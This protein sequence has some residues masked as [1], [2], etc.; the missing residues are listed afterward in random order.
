MSVV[1]ETC[2]LEAEVPWLPPVPVLPFPPPVLGLTW[3]VA[4]QDKG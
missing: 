3:L 4:A 2:T 1:I